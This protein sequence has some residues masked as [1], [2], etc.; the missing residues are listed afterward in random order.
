MNVK[1]KQA[2]TTGQQTAA[3]ITCIDMD[4]TCI[5]EP[6]KYIK[7]YLPNTSEQQTVMALHCATS[8]FCNYSRATIGVNTSMKKI[9]GRSLPC[10]VQKLLEGINSSVDVRCVGRVMSFCRMWRGQDM[11]IFVANTIWI[12]SH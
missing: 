8:N 2:I 6:A 3:H 7:T 1:P 5:T 4:I 10:F 9:E 12:Y 11:M